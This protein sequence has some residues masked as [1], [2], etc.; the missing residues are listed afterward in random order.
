MRKIAITGPESCGKSALASHLY[1][2]LG[3]TVVPEFSRLF[4]EEK[5]S[6]Y[7]YTAEDV[8]WMA[9]QTMNMLIKASSNQ[10][11]L[12]FCDGDFLVYLIW[13][14]E[15]YGRESETIYSLFEKNAFD[16]YLLMYPDLSWEPDPLRVNPH[17]RLRLFGLY[18]DEL[19]KSKLP[20][21]VIKGIGP[22]RFKAA[23][24]AILRGS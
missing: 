13:Y 4:L 22:D 5:G 16:L 12:I 11:D 2:V 6:D 10:R 17:D 3:G 9:E 7:P 23:E 24:N 1:Q 18:E 8:E 20:Y 21:V 19:R 14:R 15:I